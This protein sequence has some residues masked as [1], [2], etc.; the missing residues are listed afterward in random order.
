MKDEKGEKRDIHLPDVPFAIR[1]GATLPNDDLLY[2][3]H[4]W[5]G[6]RLQHNTWDTPQTPLCSTARAPAYHR[7]KPRPCK[8]RVQDEVDV[9]STA[10]EL[11]RVVM[12]RI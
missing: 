9:E 2:S 3:W 10:E 7:Q 5:S 12:V 6:H 4:I 1:S 11:C 8:L